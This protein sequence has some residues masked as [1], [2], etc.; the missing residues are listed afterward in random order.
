[1]KSIRDKK[2]NDNN[3][4]RVRHLVPISDERLFLHIGVFDSSIRDFAGTNRL[5]LVLDCL[6]RVG[7]ERRSVSY[8]EDSCF[9]WRHTR[10]NFPGPFFDDLGHRRVNSDRICVVER[11][12]VNV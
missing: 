1:M 4:R 5:C 10:G 7:I 6:C 11:L 12:A 9:F 8:D 2:R 3:V